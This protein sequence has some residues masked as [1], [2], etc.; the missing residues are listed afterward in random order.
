MTKERKRELLDFIFD[1]L[2][3]IKSAGRRR[4]A[5]ERSYAGPCETPTG[6][7]Q[8]TSRSSPVVIDLTVQTT[9]RTP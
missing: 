9:R 1:A 3:R 8:T 2:A 4:P 7:A 5:L 6:A